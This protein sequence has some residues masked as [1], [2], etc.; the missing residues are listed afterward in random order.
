MWRY[1]CAHV[2]GQSFLY[3][4]SLYSYMSDLYTYI[5]IPICIYICVC[6]VSFIQ[7]HAYH[8]CVS[9]WSP[10]LLMVKSEDSMKAMEANGN[11][12]VIFYSKL[13]ENQRFSDVSFHDLKYFIKT[14]VF[15]FFP[16]HGRN[17][18]WAVLAP[19]VLIG[20]T[21]F[22]QPRESPCQNHQWPES[23]AEPLV[24]HRNITVPKQKAHLADKGAAVPSDG[25]PGRS[26]G[27][28][29][30]KML[31]IMGDISN[32]MDFTAYLGLSENEIPKYTHPHPLTERRCHENERN[33]CGYQRS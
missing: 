21:S 2:D 22:Q 4:Y 30:K 26:V 1:M 33:L 25:A 20:L 9:K 6:N 13:S 17:Y 24:S 5:Y 3:M 16:R 27:F 23:I 31:L 15:D 32:K 28:L 18:W 8:C 19:K 12:M 7:W 11:S 14:N 29:R 10:Q